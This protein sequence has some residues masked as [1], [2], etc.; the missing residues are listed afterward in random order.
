M[1]ITLLLLIL[2][3]T[4][5]LSVEYMVLVP[6]QTPGPGIFYGYFGGGELRATISPANAICALPDNRDNLYIVFIENGAPDLPPEIEQLGTLADGAVICDLKTGDVRL[7]V[8][9]NYDFLHLEPTIRSTQRAA[10]AEILTADAQEIIEKVDLDQIDAY[11]YDLTQF[12]T[13]YAYTQGNNQAG[14]YIVAE[15]LKNGFSVIEESWLG[16]Q[17]QSLDAEDNLVAFT[18]ASSHLFYSTD[19]GTTF[20]D[21]FPTG[22]IEA[23]GNGAC[24]VFPPDTV[25]F[26]GGDTYHRTINGGTSWMSIQF[27]LGTETNYLSAMTF[28]DPQTGYLFSASGDVWR[29]VDGGDTWE[30]TQNTGLEVFEAVSFQEHPE[31]V[32]GVSLIETVLRSTDGGETWETVNETSGGSTLYSVTFGDADRGM[33]VGAANRVLTTDDGGETWSRMQIPGVDSTQQLYSATSLGPLEYIAGSLYGELYRTQD[34]GASWEAK[35]TGRATAVKGVAWDGTNGRVWIVTTDGPAFG[36]GD[37]DELTWRIGGIDPQTTIL[38][39]N[40]I[41]EKTGSDYPESFVYG[42][43]HFDSISGIED[44]DE[45]PYILAP[46]ANDNGSGTTA[47]LEISRVLADYTPKRSLRLAFFNAEELGLRGSFHY[48]RQLALEGIAVDGAVNL[49]M[50]VWSDP[51]DVQED[52]DVI[53]DYRS[54]WLADVV[55]EACA[56]YGDGMPGLK[57]LAPDFYRSDHA[58]FWFV[59]YPALLGIEDIDVPYPYYHKD[60]D[61]Y[62]MIRD[63]LP[64]T[65]QVTRAALGALAGLAGIHDDYLYDLTNVYTYPNPYRGDLHDGVTFNG[66]I[67][68]AELRVYDL[69]GN[70]VYETTS[71]AYELDWD[72]RNSAG[73]VLASGVYLY[74]VSTPRGDAVTAKLAVIR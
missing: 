2:L 22:E 71:N 19:G 37:V 67:P 26:A 15:L 1:K 25:H 4:F 21:Y 68:G 50:V 69:N 35:T 43:A 11:I 61:D 10:P 73:A 13:R 66:L 54:E 8:S 48:T 51:A 24:V 44:E 5:S 72:V 45:D 47:L 49:D 40:I 64:L 63:N 17:P 29:T 70:L 33:A 42:T 12:R 38:W 7:L 39:E 18:L 56:R 58:A 34:G 60:E 36:G 31:V 16:A 14:D 28:A 52:L 20:N 32:I 59:G 65:R 9:L 41:G 55:M 30:E 62:P 57:I 46:G 74:H 3:A 27:D 53:T 6:V 23:W